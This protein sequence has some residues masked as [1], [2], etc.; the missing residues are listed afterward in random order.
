MA[1]MKRVTANLPEDLL[2][3]AMAVTDEGITET[4]VQGLEMV[5][6]S[7][8]FRK[9]MDLRGKLD[10]SSIDLEMSRE[11]ERSDR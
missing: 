11:R 4:L 7:L 8:A 9:A 6:R 1:R 2:K 10:L 3:E 5:R